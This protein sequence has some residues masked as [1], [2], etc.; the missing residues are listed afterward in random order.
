MVYTIGETVLDIIFK[1]DQP[2]TTKAGGS[3]LNSAVSLGRAGIP[4]TFISET[5]ADRVG[6]MITGFLEKN[7]VSVKFIQTYPDA[8][9]P[10]ALAFLDEQGDASYS[11]YRSFPEK[12]LTG[13]LPYA[14]PDD[15]I[16]FGSFYSISPEVRNR[17]SILLTE[18]RKNNALII[19]DP[20]FRKQHLKDLETALPWIYENIDFADIIRG[21]DEDF[22]NIFG[23]GDAKMTF[24]RMN[25]KVL[26]YT[27]IK[28]MWRSFP[29]TCR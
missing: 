24:E 3:M 26:I 11:F 16:L 9:T 21:S 17:L 27:K 29:R 19:Y 7:N 8:R 13:D 20:N 25:G 1:G 12:R 28:M 10:L 23:T 15:L 6:E 22:L 5:G 2:V 4:V 14:G 18:A